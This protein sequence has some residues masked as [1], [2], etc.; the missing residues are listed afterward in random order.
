MSGYGGRGVPYG[1]IG[2]VLF[3]AVALAVNVLL[4]LGFKQTLWP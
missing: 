3:C 4:F 1:A 2:V